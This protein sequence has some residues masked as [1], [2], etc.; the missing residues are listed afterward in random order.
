MNKMTMIAA[1]ALV[2][3]LAACNKQKQSE[4]VEVL[5]TIEVDAQAPDVTPM[6][7]VPQIE[8]IPGE[9]VADRNLRQGQ[10][11]LAENAKRPE[12]TT[13]PSGLQYEVLRQGDGATPLATE[14]V[15]VNYEGRLL[16]GTVFDSS[17]QRGE[18]ITFP[19][20]RVIPGWTEGLQLMPIGSK[21]RL[22]IPSDLAYGQRGA[23][24]AI[25][26]NSTLVFDVELLDIK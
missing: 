9:S 23:G 1:A 17:Y 3:G 20:N 26:P 22:F 8:D 13:T 2:M 25:G 6:P 15:E 5:P 4:T 12:V 19:L 21:Y 11:F 7:P 10:A 24:P 18:P 14:E 16:D